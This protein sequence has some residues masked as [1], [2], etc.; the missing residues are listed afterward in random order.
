MENKTIKKGEY[1]YINFDG[2]Y[3]RVYDDDACITEQI[4]TKKKV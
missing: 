3:R 2:I 1:K 4:L